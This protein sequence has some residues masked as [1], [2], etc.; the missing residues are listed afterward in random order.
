MQATCLPCDI[1]LQV[2]VLNR[3]ISLSAHN[4]L[5]SESPWV[6]G[7]VRQENARC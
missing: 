4:H 5:N 7:V 3:G 2:E 6:P 1:E